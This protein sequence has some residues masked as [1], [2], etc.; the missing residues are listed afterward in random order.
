MA[1]RTIDPPRQPLP[2]RPPDEPS[3]PIR[4]NRVPESPRALHAQIFNP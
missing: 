3:R 4:P 1:A 2:S